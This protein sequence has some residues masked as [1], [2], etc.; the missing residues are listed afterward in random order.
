VM[1]RVDKTLK[2]MMEE[3]PASRWDTNYWH[4][5]YDELYKDINNHECYDLGHFIEL[6]TDGNRGERAFSKKKDEVIY[7]QATN[8]IDTGLDFSHNVKYIK[9]EGW[10]D[11]ERSRVSEKDILLGE[12]GVASTGRV[13]VIH[14]NMGLINISQIIALIRVKKISP[15]YIGIFLKSLFG[16]GQIQRLQSGIG[17]AKLVFDEI[18]S[19]KIPVIS[20]ESQKHIESEY[21]KMSEY[22][23][24]A[25]EAKKKG[26][27]VDYK[28]NIE[29]AKKMLKTLIAKTEAI[30]RGEKKD[31]I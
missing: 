30:I 22:H 31:I 29:T 25:M 28:K 6:I 20:K 3:K 16:Q 2:E 19:I 4:P 14:K 13:V 15:F 10:L 21:K 5:Q 24:K 17:P 11:P 1:V 27:D 18:K 12:R 9:K 26:N 8:M 23:D 7:V